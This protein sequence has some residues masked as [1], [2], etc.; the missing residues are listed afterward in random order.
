M[1]LTWAE[2]SFI[3][4]MEHWFS[5]LPWHFTE[6]KP[7]QVCYFGKFDQQIW[8]AD[9]GVTFA[10]HAYGGET[11]GTFWMGLVVASSSPFI[12]KIKLSGSHEAWI[13]NHICHQYNFYSRCS[14]IYYFQ[15]S[16][17]HSVRD[18]SGE[19]HKLLA[20]N[21]KD[22]VDGFCFTLWGPGHRKDAKRFFFLLFP[23][24]V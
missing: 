2:G 12:G 1:I 14:V 3:L 22:A 21:M 7:R 19:I 24:Q 11:L 5:G 4:I 10:W 13:F 8:L 17:K 18:C 20:E 16:L 9:V 15:W 23:I 6:F